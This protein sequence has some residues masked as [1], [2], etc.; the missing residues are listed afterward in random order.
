M[1]VAA[2]PA[3]PNVEIEVLFQDTLM[4]LDDRGMSHRTIRRV[5]RCLNQSGVLKARAWKVYWRAAYDERPTVRARVITPD[6][7][8]HLLDSQLATEIPFPQDSRSPAVEEKSLVAPLPALVP[9]AVVEEEVVIDEVTP[10][11]DHGILQH[12]LCQGPHPIR[13]QRLRVDASAGLTLHWK[14]RG[15]DVQPARSERNGRVSLLFEVGP[16][17][18][19]RPPEPYVPADIPFVTEIAFSNGKSWADAAAGYAQIVDR[20][21][22]PAA[23]ANIVRE[24][25]RGEQDR[26]RII[27]RLLTT[28]QRL[29]WNSGVNR[30]GS[31]IVPHSARQT[32]LRQFGD[33][34]DQ[35]ALLISMLRVAGIPARAALLRVSR[36]DDLIP[37]LPALNTFDHVI[38]YV[39]G[40]PELWI[41]STAPFVR[42]GQL[43]LCD[44]GRWVL[45]VSS[46]DGRLVQTPQAD[47]HEHTRSDLCE[48]WLAADGHVRAQLA[49]RFTGALDE[50]ARNHFGAARDGNNRDW[51]RDFGPR[52][53]HLTPTRLDCLR[54]KDRTQPFY[55]HVDLADVPLG[56]PAGGQIE[57]PLSMAPLMS[58]LPDLFKLQL[59]KPEEGMLGFAPLSR[60]RRDPLRLPL[61]HLRQIQY[62]I[63]PPPG[64]ALA[65]L[66]E[67]AS[68]RLGPLRLSRKFRNDG[69]LIVATFN[70][71][72]GAAT[73]SPTEL[74]SMG[75]Q[76]DRWIADQDTSGWQATLVFKRIP[77]DGG[78]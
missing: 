28:V 9:G 12:V 1:A 34:K 29:A 44:Q 46:T 15:V 10:Y 76:I 47:Y 57:L 66:P 49:S 21:A 7:G 27:S 22:D 24:E 58:E 38:V 16:Q 68:L 56:H 50:R 14:A 4:R 59:G 69:N 30:H 64:Y 61:P 60:W 18:A 74:A 36:P 75:A 43:P 31:A 5:Y 40:S 54:L 26:S 25:I 17:A 11:C 65:T 20:Q 72:T 35:A 33:C 55:F 6:G 52:F 19:F 42:M 39:P 78:R 37:D 67:S 77:V 48:F 3:P 8:E 41:D 62:R 2:L 51:W 73:L 71:D 13:K 70:L 32:L 53:E 63:V 23:V 45:V